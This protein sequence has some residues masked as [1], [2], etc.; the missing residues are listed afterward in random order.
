[1]R[2]LPASWENWAFFAGQKLIMLVP[3][4]IEPKPIGVSPEAPLSITASR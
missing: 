4:L 1:M 2:E 3:Q